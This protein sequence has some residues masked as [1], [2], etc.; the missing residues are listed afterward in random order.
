MYQLKLCILSDR[1][2]NANDP[3]EKGT[4]FGASG[5]RGPAPADPG[6]SKRRWL[7]RLFKYSSKI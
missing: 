4:I 5:C 3:E 2:A 1:K 7:W 6:Y